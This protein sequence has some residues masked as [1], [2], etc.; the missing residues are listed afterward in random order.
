MTTK[1]SPSF[2]WM[3]HK[4][5]LAR[6]QVNAGLKT[7]RL[8]QKCIKHSLPEPAIENVEKILTGLN[9]VAKTDKCQTF[10]TC[11]NTICVISAKIQ[12]AERKLAEE[13]SQ[14]VIKSLKDFAVQNQ[15][16]V[17]QI[18]DNYQALQKELKSSKSDLVKLKQTC[19]KQLQTLKEM[20]TQENADPKLLKKREK[21]QKGCIKKFAQYENDY[22]VYRGLRST[23]YSEQLPNNL[24]KLEAI[25]RLRLNTIESHVMTYMKLVENFLAEM[26][27]LHK[28][29]LQCKKSLNKTKDFNDMVTNWISQYGEAPEIP[30]VPFGLP[31]RSTDISTQKFDTVKPG[32]ILTEFLVEKKQKDE[33]GKEKRRVNRSKTVGKLLKPKKFG[34]QKHGKNSSIPAS[35]QQD[36]PFTITPELT[37]KDFFVLIEKKFGFQLN[38]LVSHFEAELLSTVGDLLEDP[39]WIN[40]VQMEKKYVEVIMH[41]LEKAQNN[42]PK[43]KTISIDA[44][45]QKSSP[46][47]LGK[48]RLPPGNETK[49][50]GSTNL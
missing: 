45:S 29:G 4:Y 32:T 35:T 12:E 8:L 49:E 46:Q 11:P 22:S 15:N 31:C 43:P 41:C 48:P 9:A 5:E 23:F 27:R 16:R 47:I 3:I 14:F 30:D 33:S 1:E 36:I 37:I 6:E 50:D 34:K 24:K 13:V 26:T 44:M 7:M 2:S 19:L 21:L 20:I 25:E 39:D 42:K 28:E 18:D 10:S 40:Q 38:D 17:K